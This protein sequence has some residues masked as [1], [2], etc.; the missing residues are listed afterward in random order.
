MQTSGRKTDFLPRRSTE[1]SGGRVPQC[2]ETA[3]GAEW[4]VHTLSA[5]H[6]ALVGVV[7]APFGCSC[8]KNHGPEG[9]LAAF[10]LMQ[11]GRTFA[12]LAR[13]LLHYLELPSMFRPYDA[14]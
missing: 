11:S 9:R 2:T 6:A 7:F 14:F 1:S 12:G 3:K 5:G 10:Y 4:R 8:L 13:E